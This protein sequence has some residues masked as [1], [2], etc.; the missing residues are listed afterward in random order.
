[1]SEQPDH[2]ADEDRA[3]IDRMHAQEVLSMMESAEQRKSEQGRWLL[4]VIARAKM[5]QEEEANPG[6]DDAA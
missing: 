2:F 1:M 3:A 5:A 6:G 4:D